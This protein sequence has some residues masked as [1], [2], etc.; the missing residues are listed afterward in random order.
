MNDD[1]SEVAILFA[2]VIHDKKLQELV[3]K[4]ANYFVDIGKKYKNLNF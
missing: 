3:D 2:Q 4:I 1:P